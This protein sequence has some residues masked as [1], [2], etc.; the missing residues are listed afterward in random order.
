MRRALH[1]SFSILLFM[2]TGRLFR[3]VAC[4]PGCPLPSKTPFKGFCS[5]KDNI[6]SNVFTNMTGD[7]KWTQKYF[8]YGEYLQISNFSMRELT[9]GQFGHLINDT[10]IGNAD[11]KISYY[12][13]S[14]DALATNAE[15]GL[16]EKS[17]EITKD[18]FLEM[19]SPRYSRDFA[20]HIISIVNVGKGCCG[21]AGVWHGGVTSALLDNMFGMLGGFFLR[22]AATKTLNV[23]FRRPIL[24]GETACIVVEFIPEPS[25][26]K[27]DRFVARGIIYNKAGE[28]VVHADSELVDVYDRWNP[29]QPKE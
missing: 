11:F 16:P 7:T 25:T 22:V 2:A 20:T 3:Y 9:K 24:A 18:K 17:I 1:I 19:L 29:S 12:I 28:E 27:L 10:L 26:N 15:A 8:K 13:N 14:T 6:F 5:Y 4:T 21:H 23:R